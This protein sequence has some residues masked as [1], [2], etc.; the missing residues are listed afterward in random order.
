MKDT[1]WEPHFEEDLLD[2][3]VNDEEIRHLTEVGLDF[4]FHILSVEE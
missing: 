1:S 2:P 3:N 4:P